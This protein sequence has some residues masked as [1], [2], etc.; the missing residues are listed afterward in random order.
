MPVSV[1][2]AMSHILRLIMFYILKKSNSIQI[3]SGI[4]NLNL[5][6][7]DQWYYNL[8]IVPRVL[9][10]NKFEL[11]RIRLVVLQSPYSPQGITQWYYNLPMVH[12]I[13]PTGTTIGVPLGDTLTIITLKI[14]WRLQHNQEIPWGL[15]GYCSTTWRYLCYHMEIVITL[16]DTL[17]II[18][19]LQCH[20][21]I[22]WG[23]YGNCSTIRR[24]LETKG[25]L[26]YHQ[27]IPWGLQYHQEI[28]WVLY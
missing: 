9:Y 21:K 14:I 15:Y 20:Q 18:W 8:P 11:N 5:I 7:L 4:I 10:L 27:E 24:Y 2:M 19:R 28:P 16:G 3:Y 6:E 23:L 12:R 17:G 26:Q 25:I 1:I 22:P 13:F